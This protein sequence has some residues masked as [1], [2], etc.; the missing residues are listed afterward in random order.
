MTTW[1]NEFRSKFEEAVHRLL[2]RQWTLLGVAGAGVPDQGRTVIDPEALL[3]ITLESAR[4]EPRLFDEVLDWLKVNGHW[5]DV[6]RLRNIARADADAPSRLLSTVAAFAAETDSTHKWRRLATPPKKP[7]KNPEPLFLQAG[8]DRVRVLNGVF[9]RYGYLRRPVETRGLS[10]PVPVRFAPC[11]RFR[12]RALFGIG[13]RAEAL[14]L[15]LARGPGHAKEIARSIAYSFPGAFQ[16]LREL[17]ASDTV[18]VRAKGRERLYWV[19]GLR[20]FEFLR[21]EEHQQPA[22]VTHSAREIGSPVTGET[23]GPRARSGTAS[24]MRLGPLAWADWREY[25]HG[26]AMILRFLRRLDLDK[27]T[28]Y[29]QDSES[30]QVFAR[31]SEHLMAAEAPFQPPPLDGRPAETYAA[32]I[33]GSLALASQDLPKKA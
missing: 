8:T 1:L 7:I 12:L 22:S 33:L 32:A 25:F 30:N 21:V 14:T 10:N 11:L 20:W 29:V 17:A 5:M 3:L 28:P 9:A 15:L 13:I 23:V 27:T 31:A 19:D 6:Q 24:L 16:A 26:L 4:T 2:W 18:H